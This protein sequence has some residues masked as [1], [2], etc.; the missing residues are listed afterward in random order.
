MQIE[1]RFNSD[2]DVFDRHTIHRRPARLT[3]L[4]ERNIENHR[5]RIR[6]KFDIPKE[7]S[8]IEFLTALE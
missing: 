2:I 4:S 1:Y 3:C 6:K 7:T 5:Y 8:I